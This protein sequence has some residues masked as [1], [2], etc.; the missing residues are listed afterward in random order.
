MLFGRHN[1]AK[2]NEEVHKATIH[3]Q[4]VVIPQYVTLHAP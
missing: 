3:L 1:A 2:H 4:S